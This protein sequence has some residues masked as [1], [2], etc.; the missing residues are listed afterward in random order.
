MA[1]LSGLVNG[2][3]LLPL[4][5]AAFALSSVVTCYLLLFSSNPLA[6]IPRIR[7][8]GKTRFS[9]RTRLDYLTD[10]R[11]LYLEAWKKY[12]SKGLVCA[13]PGFGLLEEVIIPS[14]SLRWF[15]SQPDSVVGCYESF[16][17][18]DKAEWTFGNAKFILNPWGG[19]LVRTQMGRVLEN[20]AA[21]INDEL[22]YAFDRWIGGNYNDWTEV[23]V[24]SSMKFIVAQAS[25]R[26]TIGTSLC[27]DENYLSITIRWLDYFVPIVAIIGLVPKFL[28]PLLAPIIVSPITYLTWRI[29]KV[30]EPVYN[31]RM[32]LLQNP[33]IDS[34][35]EPQ[36]HFQM[37]LRHA[38]K[39][40][41]G[42]FNF[43]DMTRRL[44]VAN[45]GSYHQTGIALTN[46][47]LNILGS[48]KQYDTISV[49]RQ[50]IHSVMNDFGDKT[51]TKAGVAKMV[52]L[53]SILR[54]TLRLHSFGNR[55]ILRRI[56]IDGFKTEDGVH[57]PKGTN[58]SVFAYPPQMDEETYKNPYEFD[59]FR[60]SRMREAEAEADVAESS[61]NNLTFVSIGP[62]YLPFSYG[63]HACPGRFLVDFE[64]KMLVAYLVM[65]YDLELPERYQ[66]QRPET[67][68]VAE[69]SFPDTSAKMRVRRRKAI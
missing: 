30:F 17:E 28:R 6:H 34:S 41:T 20:L 8:P 67:K 15:T 33:N 48:D 52:R 43:P 69:A 13:I 51:W 19:N 22:K 2:T 66:G 47:V 49:I 62:Q 16:A 12:S 31:E 50:E 27:R 35:N 4:L 63:K 25:S 42:E 18:L 64:L 9:L 45:F 37:M 68:W 59:P 60:F 1:V 29:S 5:G 24:M 14:K 58:V 54:E 21:A 61:K 53:D 56:M 38:Q 32:A 3:S 40:E 46:A 55:S 10:C 57:I 65:N 23:E 36:D 11:Q 39:V 7:N 26:F 44:L